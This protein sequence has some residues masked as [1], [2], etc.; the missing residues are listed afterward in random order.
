[1]ANLT[2][3]DGMRFVLHG[4]TWTSHR[5]RA[6]TRLTGGMRNLRS[7]SPIFRQRSATLRRTLAGPQVSK[8][9]ISKSTCRSQVVQLLR[10]SNRE[11][12][13]RF[14]SASAVEMS[15]TL[16]DLLLAFPTGNKRGRGPGGSRK[17][18]L[19]TVRVTDSS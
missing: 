10:A 19:G 18:I 7:Y 8:L 2:L 13:D 12:L 4:E 16:E 17:P 5:T 9:H 1:M 3:R 14:S 11:I 15:W 6:E